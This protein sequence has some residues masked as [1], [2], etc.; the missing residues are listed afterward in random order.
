[1]AVL[2]SLLC[3]Q[4]MAVITTPVATNSGLDATILDSLY[5]GV[6][7]GYSNCPTGLVDGKFFAV[8]DIATGKCCTR[9]AGTSTDQSWI[10]ISFTNPKIFRSV[11]I[12][13]NEDKATKCTSPSEMCWELIKGSTLRVGHNENPGANWYC[14]NQNPESSGIWNC[15]GRQGTKLGLYK[16]KV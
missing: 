2:A 9:T 11:L 16:G 12:I 8:P 10:N 14:D 3:A 5:S 7:T 15:G 1:M 13:N 6:L 4:A